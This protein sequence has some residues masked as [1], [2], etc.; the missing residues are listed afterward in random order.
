M[1]QF[2][3]IEQ[4]DPVEMILANG[5]AV[6]AKY[7]RLIRVQLGKQTNSKLENVYYIPELCLNLITCHC[8]DKMVITTKIVVGYCELYH[9]K[10]GN[11]FL[12]QSPLWSSDRL[13]VGY[14]LEPKTT[15]FNMK[16]SRCP[17]KISAAEFWQRPLGH[18]G[19]P[20]FRTY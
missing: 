18:A 5:Y 17:A 14:R 6:T 19:Q 8:S 15:V 13:F 16:F 12:G 3:S 2:K 1:V 10:K 11:R 4:I 9:R 7:Y 20:W